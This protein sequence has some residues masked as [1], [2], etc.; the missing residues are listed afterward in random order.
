MIDVSDSMLATPAPSE[1]KGQEIDSALSASLKC[2]YELM[3]SRI[4]SNPND[5]MGVLFHGVDTTNLDM[6]EP[7][8]ASQEIRIC[9]QDYLLVD[10]CIPSASDV[11]RLKDFAEDEATLRKVVPASE[12]KSLANTLFYAGGIF[13]S[14]AANF[15]SRRLFIITDNDDPHHG[16]DRLKTLSTQRA[17]DLFDLEVIIELFPVVQAGLSFDKTKFYN[18]R[19]CIAFPCCNVSD[20]GGRT[21]YTAILPV[22]RRLLRRYP[23]TLRVTSIKGPT[24]YWPPCSH[25]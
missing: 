20:R 3:T 10:L 15:A 2:A 7:D 9:P 1:R 19:H 5:M 23:T 6:V 18:V 12:G 14:R 4:T 25:P 17:K 16:N 21:S 22:M 11:K 13:R 24:I 8:P